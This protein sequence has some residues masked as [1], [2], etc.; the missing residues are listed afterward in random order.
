MAHTFFCKKCGKRYDVDPAMIGKRARC[1]ACQRVFAIPDFS[2]AAG[3]LPDQPAARP[4][5]PVRAPYSATQNPYGMQDDDELFSSGTGK[6][7]AT[8]EPTPNRVNLEWLKPLT[9]YALIGGMAVWLITAALALVK[10]PVAAFLALGCLFIIGFGMLMIGSVV[11]LIVP[12]FENVLNGLLFLLV[13]FY[14][15]YYVITRW[16]AMKRPFLL[17]LAGVGLLATAGFTAAVIVPSEPSPE[18]LAVDVHPEVLPQPR[19]PPRVV[20]KP[21]PTPGP[22]AKRDDQSADVGAPPGTSPVRKVRRGIPQEVDDAFVAEVL[23]DLES[24]D[25][26]VRKRALGRLRGA[27]PTARRAEVAKAVEP[28]LH[29]P[30]GFARTDAAKALAVWGGPENTPALIEGLRDASFGVR[31]AVLD[32]LK[33][34]KD[35]VSASA[36]AEVLATNDRGKAGEAL[37]AIGSEAEDAVIPYL[38]GNDATAR[39]EACKVLKV[40]GTAKA[41]ADLRSVAAM[42]GLEGMAARDALGEIARRTNNPLFNYMPR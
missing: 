17:W 3:R 5:A 15:V 41:V 22:I 27:A 2:S 14:N 6:S 34:L 7:F 31:W 30:D 26:Q 18:L 36:L 10:V 12:F 25:M 19:R 35:P 37:K 23:A 20:R 11:G 8:E 32:T 42:R 39:R 16:Q 4:A 13:P 29:D 9:L 24:P 38:K 1:K 33:A 21:S 28:M 40:I